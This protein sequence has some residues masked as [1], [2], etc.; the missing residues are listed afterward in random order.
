MQPSS[1]PLPGAW[2]SLLIHGLRNRQ[3]LPQARGAA[4]IQVKTAAI[5][6]A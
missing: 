4:L 1:D 3:C 2:S 6:A 5:A